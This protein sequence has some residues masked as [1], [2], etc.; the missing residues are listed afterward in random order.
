MVDHLPGLLAHGA[1]NIGHAPGAA[2]DPQAAVVAFAG[3]LGMFALPGLMLLGPL[4]VMGAVRAR[5][6]VAAAGRRALAVQA[7]VAFTVLLAGAVAL[8]ARTWPTHYLYPL[9]GVAV[10]AAV[11]APIGRRWTAGVLL[12]VAA[13]QAVGWIGV[14][15]NRPDWP[16]GAPPLAAAGT[17]APLVAAAGTVRT[18]GGPVLVAAPPKP[19][20]R[21]TLTGAVR[22]AMPA[23]T[24]LTTRWPLL[25]PGSRA[26]DGC[27]LVWTGPGRPAIVPLGTPLVRRD[28]RLNLSDG[29][30]IAGTAA[31]W[32]DAAACRGALARLRAA[33]GV[34]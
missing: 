24:V 28:V 27:T 18:G 33:S 12:L 9:A 31:F 11:A 22:V 15:G 29:S 16:P 14:A 8:D 10:L 34:P 7:A 21:G 30:R 5:C 3:A 17:A 32:A 1:I 20:L 4:G 25:R 26:A 19:P 6:T 23:A 2:G 13:V